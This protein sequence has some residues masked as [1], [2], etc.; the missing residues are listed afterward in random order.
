MQFDSTQHLLQLLDSAFAVSLNDLEES[1]GLPEGE[2]LPYQKLPEV[3]LIVSLVSRRKSQAH[4]PGDSTVRS[5]DLS[6][7]PGINLVNL[8]GG[9]LRL[10][11]LFLQN[12]FELLGQVT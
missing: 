11:H 10:E 9:K 5:Q 3:L 7:E 4:Q 6:V 2:T 1:I 12:I 8:A